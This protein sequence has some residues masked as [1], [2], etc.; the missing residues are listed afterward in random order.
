[1]TISL[2]SPYFSESSDCESRFGC[3]WCVKYCNGTFRA[4]HD[5]FC[6]Y[7]GKCCEETDAP[8]LTPESGKKKQDTTLIVVLIVV[9]LLFVVV[10]SLFGCR[11]LHKIWNKPSDP[12]KSQNPEKCT[13]NTGNK[14]QAFSNNEFNYPKLDYGDVPC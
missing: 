13:D 6:G 12:E 4:D 1:M 9:V 5:K 3:E 8:S 2:Q 10:L 14:N 11:H 7:N